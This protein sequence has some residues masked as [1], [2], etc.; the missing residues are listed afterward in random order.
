[1]CERHGR[2][3]QG[4][5]L[6]PTMDKFLRVGVLCAAVF[7]YAGET[8]AQLQV[9]SNITAAQAVQN[10]LLGPGITASNITFSGN[11]SQLGSFIGTN[12]YLGLDSGVIMATGSVI[13]ALGPNNQTSATFP[14]GGFNGPGDNDL[15]LA[16]GG[17]FPQTHDAAV[18]QFDFIPTGDSLSFRFVFA[19]D[20][21]LVYVGSINDVFGFFLSGPGF[22]GPYSNGAVNIALV[23]GT[24]NPVS[25]NSVN[26]VSNS[27]YYVNNGTGS[28]APYNA[29]N[30]Y[31]QYNGL[32]TVLTA[33]ANVQCGQTYHIK[34]AI[35]DLSDAIL[36][37]GVF[38]QAG[39]F[40]SNAVLLST[41]INSGGQDST[42]YEGCG[43]ATFYVTRQGDLT[44]ADTVP[45]V[46]AGTATEGLDYDPIP[47]PL[48]FQPGEDTITVTIDALYDG[49][50]EP[51]ELIDLL[52][53]W[54]G[55]CGADSTRLHLYIADTPPIDLSL[56]NDT[57]LTCGDSVLVHA[58]AMGG[59][60][61]LL[62]DWSTGIPDGDPLAW[63]HPPQT[64]TYVLTV[65]DE[66]GIYSATDSV[67]INI[68]VPAPYIL[69]VQPDTLVHC[70]ESPI[71]L[72]A[73][74]SGGTPPYTYAWSE[75]GGS[76]DELYV[77]PAISHGYSVT[78]TDLCGNML[79]GATMV[80][81]DYDS[82][83]VA[84]VP[85]TLICFRDSVTVNAVALGGFGGLFYAW[86]TGSMETSIPVHP[87]HTSVY[88]ATVTDQCGIQASAHATVNVERPVADFA[89]EGSTWESNFPISFHDQSW[90]A[91]AWSWNFGFPGLASLDPNPTIT[92]PDPGHFPVRLAIQDTLGCVDT[93][94]RT[95]NVAPEFN[96][97]FPTAFSP[98]GDGI[99]E[100][101]GVVGTNIQNFHMLIYDRWG[102]LAFETEDPTEGWDG[103][104][105][106][107]KPVPGVY[108]YLYRYLGPSG[109]T[110]DRYGSVLLFR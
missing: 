14:G 102:K 86:N 88:W 62:L 41:Q 10:I 85:D 80:T 74:V 60:G 40:Q 1:M 94:V 19:S 82:M 73:H 15:Y 11:A 110:A 67:T 78:T 46:A 3:T 17:G 21:Y 106:G 72:Y 104:M 35:A 22:S 69:N 71:T 7:L 28:N 81:V 31:I 87:E 44:V 63:L 18:L 36:D 27:A 43:N 99:N 50:P 26:N 38:L 96:L 56:N 12:C 65:T 8:R 24:T 90:G 66:C 25:I 57:L 107:K 33:N 91:I 2:I 103:S 83:R 32:T 23:P 64:T 45:L 68:F 97:Y 92:Y 51:P 61:D 39:S 20:E 16:A 6:F 76:T 100:V 29:N 9:T 89:I 55:D 98:D 53:T 77:A 108:N 13:G 42:L 95:I 4:S 70:P 49:I 109:Q 59:F 58:T 48:V 37:S 93:L 105:N 34:L 101:F 30:Q 5:V 47:S 84:V 75:G 52:A 54:T 79:S